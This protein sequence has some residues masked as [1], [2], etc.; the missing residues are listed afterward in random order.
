MS[1]GKLRHS[2]PIN[3]VG[4]DILAI[5]DKKYGV[6]L[7]KIGEASSKTNLPRL[8]FIRSKYVPP[9]IGTVS[10]MPVKKSNLGLQ[11]LVMSADENFLISKRANMEFIRDITGESEFLTAS[12][13]KAVKAE[14]IEGKK[15]G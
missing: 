12:I 9:S 13:L 15:T 14:R 5:C 1:P 7:H 2:G 3:P 6:Y 10:M 8:F 4:V 11:K